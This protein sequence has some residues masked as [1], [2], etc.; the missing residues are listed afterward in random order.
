ML[1]VDGGSLLFISSMRLLRLLLLL[2]ASVCIS[3]Q[4]V[5]TF[6]SRQQRSGTFASPNFPKNYPPNVDCSYHFRGAVGEVVAINWTNFELE[7][8][9]ERTNQ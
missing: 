3:Q 8:P 5:Q 2:F 4:C 6:T 9:F 7:E 1:D